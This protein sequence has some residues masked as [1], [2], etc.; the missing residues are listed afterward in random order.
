MN[1]FHSAKEVAS[2]CP[3]GS[4]SP[5]VRVPPLC[6]VA[7]VCAPHEGWCCCCCSRQGRRISWQRR[8]RCNQPSHLRRIRCRQLQRQPPGAPVARSSLEVP[9][10]TDAFDHSWQVSTSEPV[11]KQSPHGLT[12]WKGGG[13]SSVAALMLC[14][15]LSMQSSPDIFAGRDRG[16]CGPRRRLWCRRRPRRETNRGG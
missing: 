11:Q 14:T 9:H 8:P 12:A 2:G 10:S 5:L 7:S 1:D 3:R 6:P 16:V 13:K 15:P 4:P